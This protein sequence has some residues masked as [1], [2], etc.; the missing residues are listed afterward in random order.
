MAGFKSLQPNLPA[1]DWGPDGP[2]AKP[3]SSHCVKSTF[4]YRQKSTSLLILIR[5]V[6]IHRS[7]DTLVSARRLISLVVPAEAFP[8]TRLPHR[9][10][11]LDRSA[12][13]LSLAEPRDSP[14]CGALCANLANWVLVDVVQ[15]GRSALR[16]TPNPR[17]KSRHMSACTSPS[18]ATSP[19]LSG[20]SYHLGS[21][22]A[23]RSPYLTTSAPRPSLSSPSVRT[24]E[25]SPHYSPHLRQA[26]RP[27]TRSQY[28][29]AGTQYTPEGSPPTARGHTSS[30]GPSQSN[31]RK[32]SPSDIS[33]SPTAITP[34]E[35]ASAPP[36]PDLR[37]VPAVTTDNVGTKQELAKATIIKKEKTSPSD[38]NV[39]TGVL[40]SSP[41]KRQRMGSEGV[42]IMPAKY[43]DGN[44]KDLGV[45]IANM[46]MELIR[47]NDSLPLRDG[48]LTR[49][50]SRYFS[51]QSGGR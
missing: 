13:V 2:R 15:T 23:T 45:L 38:N 31:K 8:N 30:G 20:Y 25:S 29:D 32:S 42:K 12:T 3:L 10:P 28:A 36:E 37:E 14:R 47:Q 44:A 16:D 7:L 26:P 34:G 50:H 33:M 24:L 43:E 48:Q 40:A 51:L 22:P 27:L 5:I 39:T 49:F 18:L 21:H 19:S 46:L 1:I 17:Q 6:P 35:S 11:P 4:T 41:V 9:K